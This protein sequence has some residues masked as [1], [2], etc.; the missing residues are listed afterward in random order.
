[1]YI[2]IYLH[3]CNSVYL[4]LALIGVRTFFWRRFNWPN[5]R[6]YSEVR[7]TVC[8]FGCL[9]P[10]WWSFKL[11]IFWSNCNRSVLSNGASKLIFVSVSLIYSSLIPRE[12]CSSVVILQRSSTKIIF[13]A[14]TWIQARTLR[15]NMPFRLELCVQTMSIAANEYNN[16]NVN[17]STIW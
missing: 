17:V 8:G 10:P 11:H 7:G 9:F 14:R 4:I 12:N 15:L 6:G 13:F 3:T 2:Y 16:V 1:M 5:T